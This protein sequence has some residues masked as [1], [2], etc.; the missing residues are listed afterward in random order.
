MAEDQD[1][2]PSSKTEEPS[3]RKLEDARKRGQVPLSREVST[4]LM[5]VTSTLVVG[6]MIPSV[7]AQMAQDMI[8]YMEQSYNLP[9]GH[10]GIAQVLSTSFWTVLTVLLP[11]FLV[12]MAGG[13]FFFFLLVVPLLAPEFFLS[14]LQKKSFF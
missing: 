4:W 3:Q 9:T 10:G 8:P 2:D 7:F 13:F 5:L 14:A 12:L 1:Q 6:A 11:V